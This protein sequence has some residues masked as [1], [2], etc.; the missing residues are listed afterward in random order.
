MHVALE[1]MRG[2]GQ[3]RAKDQHD[4]ATDG[5]VQE[6]QPANPARAPERSRAHGAFDRG[7]SLAQDARKQHEHDQIERKEKSQRR[8]DRLAETD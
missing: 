7:P 6:K 1:I 8:I 4:K 5:D 2:A 3:Q